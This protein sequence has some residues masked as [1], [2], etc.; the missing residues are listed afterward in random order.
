MLLG[1][2]DMLPYYEDVVKDEQGTPL[3]SRS[4]R[5]FTKANDQLPQ[6]TEEG[7]LT[8]G[9][10]IDHTTKKWETAVSGR[11]SYLVRMQVTKI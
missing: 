7:P 5:N 9:Y 4:H 6:G 1:R 2:N 8:Q 3:S 10:T 11:K